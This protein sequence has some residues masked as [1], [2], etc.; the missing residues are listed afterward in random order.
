[1]QMRTMDLIPF[2]AITLQDEDPKAFVYAWRQLHYVS[3]AVVE[4][5]KSWGESRDDDSHSAMLYS[6]DPIGFASE[7]D[8]SDIRATWSAGS[9]TV[10]VEHDPGEQGPE[11][12]IAIDYEGL[13]L[14]QLTDWVKL[15]A[16]RFGGDAQQKSKP[17]PDL[18][19]HPLAGDAVFEWRPEVSIV[20]AHYHITQRLLE[21]F[22]LAVQSA[23]AESEHELVP[24]LWPHH[25]DLASLL[26]VAR[27]AGGNMTK[28][29]G[30][31]FTPPDPIDDSGYWYVSPWV[32]DGPSKAF[33][34]PELPL[35]RWVDRGGTAMAV[36]PVSDI[37]NIAEDDS[38]E[39][40][41]TVQGCAI[42]EF[43]ATAFNACMELM[44]D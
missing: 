13:T 38:L 9:T 2:D 43:V 32:K 7:G 4:V 37:W 5:G 27:D 40:P 44:N 34:R 8:Q 29:I 42:A 1:M 26:V 24:R 14:A 19:D 3:Q 11:E 30:V 12:F 25:F 20:F 39:D 15:N 16:Q 41:G 10:T 22:V 6:D 17:A 35:G 23:G 28:T 18:P 33:A 21:R 31:G 36:L